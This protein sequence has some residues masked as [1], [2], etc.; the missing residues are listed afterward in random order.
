MVTDIPIYIYIYRLALYKIRLWN[1]DALLPHLTNQPHALTSNSQVLLWWISNNA[2]CPCFIAFRLFQGSHFYS[3]KYDHAEISP[4]VFC[5]IRINFSSSDLGR[6]RSIKIFSTISPKLHR[7]TIEHD[8]HHRYK[9][10]N[11]ELQYLICWC[12]LPQFRETSW[13]D[14]WDGWINSILIL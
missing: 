13:K 5:S 4:F 3:C 9:L 10:L 6:S 14:F 2:E 1:M 7:C 12:L 11:L 8:R